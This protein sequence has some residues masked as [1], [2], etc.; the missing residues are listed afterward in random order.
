MQEGEDTDALCRTEEILI[1]MPGSFME[2]DEATLMLFEIDWQEG[3]WMPFSR[4]Q[5]ARAKFKNGSRVRKAWEDP[6][7]DIN[8]KGSLGTV[9]GSIGAADIVGYFIEWD[10]LPR[11]PTFTAEPKLEQA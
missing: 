7:G 10:S 9:L 5:Y 11:L 1:T 2:M 8:P 3:Y 4:Q 6:A